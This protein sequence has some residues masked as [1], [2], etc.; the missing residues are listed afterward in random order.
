M[1]VGIQNLTLHKID[2]SPNLNPDYV[3]KAAIK[4]LFLLSG[5]NRDLLK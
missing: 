5:R 4:Y 2:G 1:K 3:I